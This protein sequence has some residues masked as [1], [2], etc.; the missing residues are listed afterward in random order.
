MLR[1]LLVLSILIPGFFLALRGRFAALQLY[2]WFGLFRPQEWVWVDLSS[3]RLSLVLGVILVAPSLATGIYPNVT[4]PLSI[5]AIAFFLT[6]LVA[7]TGA[8]NSAVGW[9]WIDYL[10]RL[11]LVCLLAV[12]LLSSRKRFIGVVAVIAGS[13]GFHSVK[14]GV[15]SLLAGGSRYSAGLAGSFEDSNG[16][17][18]AIVMILPLLMVVGQNLDRRW[19]KLTFFGAVPLCALAA[20]STFSRAGFL[21]I[22][23]STLTFIALQRRRLA[24]A[25]GLAAVILVCLLVVPIPSGYLDR[26]QTIQTYEEVG[27]DSAMSRPHFWRVAVAMAMAHPLG[28]GLR[29]YDFAYDSF[30]FLHGRYGNRRSVHS[31]FFQA[32]SETGF[33]GLAIYLALFAYAFR[34][35]LRVRARSTHPGLPPDA[36]HFLFTMSNALMTSM[37]GFIVGG[38]FIA[39]TLNDITWL[40]F[41][42]LTSLDL[43]SRKMCPASVRRERPAVRIPEPGSYRSLMVEPASPIAARSTLARQA[44]RSERLA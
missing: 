2:L 12:P 26:I 32:L 10:G 23:A 6:T 44:S 39:L 37:V 34:V 30:D 11:L 22:S 36:Q 5:G 38:S 29:N 15:A 31:S 8:Y 43:L 16:Y 17:A 35:G 42:L 21:A 41:A 13:L 14:A 3:L 40:T 27:D 25:S 24:M 9:D 28:V 33:I 4:H 7:Q 18:L 19:M 1:S 20:V